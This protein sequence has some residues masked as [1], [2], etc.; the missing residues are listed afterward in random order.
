MSR[1]PKCGGAFRVRGFH[2][3]AGEYEE[4]ECH[5]WRFATGAVEQSWRCYGR[6]QRRKGHLEAL[7]EV[8]ELCK[9]DGWVDWGKT[10]AR[11]TK[12]RL[13]KKRRMG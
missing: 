9:S 5:T 12:R 7:R 4:F 2:P 3:E 13:A 11:R 10:I 8:E 1:C 6:E